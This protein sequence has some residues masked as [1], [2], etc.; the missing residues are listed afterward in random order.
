MEDYREDILATAELFMGGLTA[1]QSDI[2]L[3]LIEGIYDG[4]LARLGTGID[5]AACKN[6]LIPACALY[7]LSMYRSMDRE[8]ISAFTAGTLSLSF[9]DHSSQLTQMADSL[10]APWL[11]PAAAFRSVVS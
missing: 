7:A 10:L 8:N 4:L 6:A 5:P 11:R 3:K 9:A 2:L 1:S